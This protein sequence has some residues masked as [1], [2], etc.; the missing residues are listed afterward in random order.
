MTT[1]DLLKSGLSFVIRSP[2]STLIEQPSWWSDKFN[3]KWVIEAY[4]HDETAM[5]LGSGLTWEEMM[6][7]LEQAL[8]P[9][10]GHDLGSV[11]L[12]KT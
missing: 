11:D 6:D 7:D 12:R 3:A 1:D 2:H 9:E 4:D 8:D 5:F 10:L